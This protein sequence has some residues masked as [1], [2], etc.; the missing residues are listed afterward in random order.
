MSEKSHRNV[1]FTMFNYTDEDE[2]A[3]LTYKKAKY[4]VFGREICPTTGKPH[5]QGYM[6]LSSS[7][8]Y[9]TLLKAFP[10]MRR[11]E[12]YGTPLEAANYCKKDGNFFEAGTMSTQ[13]SRSDIRIVAEAL[14][15]DPKYDVLENNPEVLAKYPRF[16]DACYSRY[17]PDRNTMPTVTWHWGLSGSGK[18][19][20][21]FKKSN[22]VYIKP[23]GAWWPGYQQQ[24]VV[25]LDDFSPSEM[26]FRQLLRLLDKYPLQVPIKGGFVKFNSP[27]IYITCDRSPQELYCNLTE[28]E[29]DQLLRRLTFIRQFTF[30][31]APEVTDKEIVP[32][33]LERQPNVR[34]E[35]FDIHL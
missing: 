17:A 1:C 35:E 13:G 27:H 33:P 9:S 11:R 32:P 12:R 7:T 6:E 8:L 31:Y 3:I 15:T 4:V 5:L 18:T 2:K 21:A 20:E 14:K 25:I 10:K 16:V 29:M 22:R 24:E 30:K 28:A 19:H 26:S 23:E 34:Q